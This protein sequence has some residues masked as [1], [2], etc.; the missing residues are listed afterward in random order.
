MFINTT[1]C[2]NKTNENLSYTTQRVKTEKFQWRDLQIISGLRR[3][4]QLRKEQKISV[5][6]VKRAIFNFLNIIS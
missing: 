6:K 1:G 2:L 5:E 3:G 4:R